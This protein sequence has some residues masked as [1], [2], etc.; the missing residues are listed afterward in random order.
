MNATCALSTY[1]Q[2]TREFYYTPASG[3]YKD[4]TPTRLLPIVS[5]LRCPKP[6]MTRSWVDAARLAISLCAQGVL[7]KKPRRANGRTLFGV[8]ALRTGEAGAGSGAW[9]PNG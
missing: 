4:R 9:L 1:R 3:K 2:R 7:L 8:N 6:D 5:W